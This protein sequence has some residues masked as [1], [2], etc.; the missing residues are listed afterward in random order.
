MLV[1]KDYEEMSQFACQWCMHKN[2][3]VRQ[4]ATGTHTNTVAV[5]SALYTDC[6]PDVSD[7]CHV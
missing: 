7:L 4:C 1:G 3:K 6:A 5:D 2:T